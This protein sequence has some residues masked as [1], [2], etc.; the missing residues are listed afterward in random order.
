MTHTRASSGTSKGMTILELMLVVAI[1]TVLAGVGFSVFKGMTKSTG[2]SSAMGQISA[3]IGVARA[4][5]MANQ[6]VTGILFY[7]PGSPL[8]RDGAGNYSPLT[9]TLRSTGKV[10][11]AI[12]YATEVK[13]V[14][15]MEGKLPSKTGGKDEK[16]PPEPEVLLDIAD[17]DPINL[18]DTICVQTL[19][20][21]LPDYHL[22]TYQGLNRTRDEFQGY[23]RLPLGNNYNVLSAPVGGVILFDPTGQLVQMRYAFRTKYS[24]L[25]DPSQFTPTQ[26]FSTIFPGVSVDDPTLSVKDAMTFVLVNMNDDYGDRGKSPVSSPALTLFDWNAFREM[27]YNDDDPIFKEAKTSGDALGNVLAM[28]STECYQEETWIEKYGVPCIISRYSGALQK[29]K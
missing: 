3:A 22:Y 25:K 2:N 11:I 20:S 19:L 16:I 29:V 28:L 10:S 9:S 8:V 17:M 21:T 26:F 27:R 13:G 5:A 14:L 4:Q 1:L 6:R 7:I 15:N 12:V 23:N 18:P 24:N